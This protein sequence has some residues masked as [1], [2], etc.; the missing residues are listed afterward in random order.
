MERK[1]IVLA[2]ILILVSCFVFLYIEHF[3]LGD[4]IPTWAMP[5]CGCCIGWIIGYIV[6]KL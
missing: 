2:I 3:I 1:K 5:I 4:I 6:G